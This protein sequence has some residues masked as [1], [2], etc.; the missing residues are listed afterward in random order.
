M[1]APL[2]VIK[3]GWFMYLLIYLCI[4]FIAV[5]VVLKETGQC[6]RETDHYEEV[7]EGPNM[8]SEVKGRH[9]IDEK[10]K[11]YYWLFFE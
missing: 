9:N 6:K 11:G 5:Y 7:A 8:K 1:I 4:Y 3:F 10:C 2:G